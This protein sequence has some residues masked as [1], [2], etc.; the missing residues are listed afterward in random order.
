MTSAS[1]VSSARSA[2]HQSAL[3]LIEAGEIDANVLRAWRESRSDA[4]RAVRSV[5]V[6][7]PFPVQPVVVRS[8]S[9]PGLVAAVAEQL[10]RPELATA[11]VRFGLTGFGPVTHDDY[12]RLGLPR[13]TRQRLGAGGVGGGLTPPD[14][15]ASLD[16]GVRDRSGS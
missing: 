10:A 2:A 7:G 5:D 12:A 3:A 14:V 1:S 8:G 6:L 4:G 15:S 13:R 9:V 16:P 11:V